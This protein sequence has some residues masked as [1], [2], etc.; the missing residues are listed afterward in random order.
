MMRTKWR[1][2]FCFRKPSITMKIREKCTKSWHELSISFL[3]N[4][5]MSGLWLYLET[6]KQMIQQN[7][8]SLL[9]HFSLNCHLNAKQ[10]CICQLSCIG[11]QRLQEMMSWIFCKDVRAIALNIFKTFTSTLDIKKIDLM[12]NQSLL[13]IC[14]S[15]CLNICDSPTLESE[16]QILNS[17][18]GPSLKRKKKRMSKRLKIEHNS[19]ISVRYFLIWLQSRSLRQTNNVCIVRGRW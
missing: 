16:P 17:L 7:L 4:V 13:K 11:H 14:C 5:T 6:R 1:R 18:Q 3:K 15:S 12:V 2:T 10:E 8:S 9:V 19:M